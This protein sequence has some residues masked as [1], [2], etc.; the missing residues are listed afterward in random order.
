[1]GPGHPG[2]YG[3][4]PFPGRPGGDIQP[5]PGQPGFQEPPPAWAFPARRRTLVVGA[6][7]LGVSAVATAFPGAFLVV[8]AALLVLTATTGWAGRSRRASRLRRGVRQGDDARML[9]GLPWHLVRGVLSSLPGALIG[10]TVGAA[11]WWI[12]TALGDPRLVEPI[13]LWAAALL[14]LLAAWFA[15]G[16]RA[17]RDGARAMVE[18]LTP[19]RGF[20]ALLVVLV[21]LVAVV[22]VAQTVLV[23]PAPPSWSPLPGPPFG[24]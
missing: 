2:G 12:L 20:R 7:G 18:V 10:V 13:V 1:M 6:V 14:A 8:V 9:A 11:T 24:F 5:Y 15:P 17:A 19:T 21:L 3:A 16:G 23:A 22:L 4:E